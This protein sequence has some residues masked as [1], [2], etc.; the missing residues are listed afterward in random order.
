MWILTILLSCWTHFNPPV[1]HNLWTVATGEYGHYKELKDID[2]KCRDKVIDLSQI[3]FSFHS[4]KEC[5]A[6]ASMAWSMINYYDGQLESISSI[7]T[8]CSPQN[9]KPAGKK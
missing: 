9:N 6:G 4:L 2:E 3:P 7:H 1:E 8:K 5:K